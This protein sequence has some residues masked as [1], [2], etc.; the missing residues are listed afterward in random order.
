MTFY[1]GNHTAVPVDDYN[2][3]WPIVI[4]EYKIAIEFNSLT[5]CAARAPS[6]IAKFYSA[7]PVVSCLVN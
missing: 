5:N 6:T 7:S 3:R 2:F 4:G 1:L